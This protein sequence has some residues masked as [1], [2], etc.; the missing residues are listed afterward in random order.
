[1]ADNVA[2]QLQKG[3]SFCRYYANSDWKG[4]WTRYSPQGEISESFNS[5]RSFQMS[6]DGGS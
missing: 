1:M 2:A 3:D 5:I 6:A 4:T